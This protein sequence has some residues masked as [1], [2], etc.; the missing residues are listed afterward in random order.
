MVTS[1]VDRLVLVLIL[2]LACGAAAQLK[3][4]AA[5]GEPFPVAQPERVPRPKLPLVGSVL[6]GTPAELAPRVFSVERSKK[7]LERALGDKASLAGQWFALGLA[8]AD[9]AVAST[10]DGRIFSVSLWYQPATERRIRELK[11]QVAKAAKDD[12]AEKNDF[13]IET[14]PIPVQV[15]FTPIGRSP[16][17]P[18]SIVVIF[19]F[20]AVEW[21]LAH[22]DVAAEVADAMR[23]RRPVKGMSEAQAMLV[24]GQPTT[25]TDTDDGKQMV[26]ETRGEPTPGRATLT[27]R[28]I[29]RAE[30]GK[31]VRVVTVWF[32]AGKIVN[33]S[34]EKYK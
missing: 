28:V 34:D 5:D 8:G 12:R 14:G 3:D 6:G 26:W 19:S 22:H 32:V 4:K 17:N 15:R 7:Q 27:G 18:T 24:F 21:Y 33:F 16:E 11:N 31:L 20:P 23:A 25:T 2:I 13:V 30:P 10:K 1:Q 29:Q 9:V